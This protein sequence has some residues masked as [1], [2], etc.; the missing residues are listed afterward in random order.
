MMNQK[1]SLRQTYN[2]VSSMLT[3]TAQ[4]IAYAKTDKDRGIYCAFPFLT[5]VRV[6][7]QLGL[8]WQDIDLENTTITICRVQERDGSTTDTTKTEAGER[9]I[10]ISATLRTMLLE[11][12]LACP[13][14][15]D[16]LY[17]VFPGPCIPQQWPLPRKGGGGQFFIPTSS[18]DTGDR[19]SKNLASDM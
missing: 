4:L 16:E 7:E 17:R 12:R 15:D 11:W 1:L 8:L 13:K 3:G 18:S 2:S 19:P 10:P 5:G 6:F 14:L 9:S